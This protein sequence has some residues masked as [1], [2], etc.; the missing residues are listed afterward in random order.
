[1]A[2]ENIHPIFDR[3]LSREERENRLQ[4]RGK[5]LWLTGLSGSGKSTIAQGLEHRLF[6]EGYFPQVLDGDNIRI[7]INNNLGFSLEDREENI[8]RIAEVAKLYLNSGVIVLCS[9]IS[10]TKAIREQ[11]EQII[12]KEDFLE[13]FIDTPLD[14]C[15]ARDVKGLYAKA[16]RGEIKGFTGIDSPYEAPERAFLTVPTRD[17]TVEDAVTQVYTAL[18]PVI[19]LPQ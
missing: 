12:G 19:S 5:V 15:E 1:M 17:M 4:Q 8:R 16:R 18:L 13:I 3:L 10:P 6:A 11:A 9:F 7:G 14:V 2:T